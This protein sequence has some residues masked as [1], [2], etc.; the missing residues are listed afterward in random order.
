MFKAG[1]DYFRPKECRKII[2]KWYF[3]RYDFIFG[4]Y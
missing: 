3:G 1:V 2:E 4:R